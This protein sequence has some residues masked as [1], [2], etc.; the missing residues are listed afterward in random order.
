MCP[1]ASCTPG[2]R[3]VATTAGTMADFPEAGSNQRD[4]L[5][6][7]QPGKSREEGRKWRGYHHSPVQ[8]MAIRTGL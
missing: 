8:V 3:L 6:A 1:F 2:S 4:R 5:Q 7:E